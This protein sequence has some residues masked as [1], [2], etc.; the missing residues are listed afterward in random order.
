MTDES[1]ESASET[2]EI[3]VAPPGK[4]TLKVRDRKADVFYVFRVELASL[5]AGYNSPWGVFFGVPVGVVIALVVA[6]FTADLGSARPYF[7]VGA[8]AAGFL[9][10]AMLIAY[11]MDLRR[12]AQLVDA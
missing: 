8:W 11:V 6:L 1:P 12:A 7:F 4:L 2:P 10:V 3:A 9:V 5:A